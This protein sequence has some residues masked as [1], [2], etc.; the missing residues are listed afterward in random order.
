MGRQKTNEERTRK[1][2]AKKAQKKAIKQLA[3]KAEAT[4]E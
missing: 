2:M 1:V 3:R 4:N